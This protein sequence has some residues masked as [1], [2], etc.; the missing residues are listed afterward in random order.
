MAIKTYVYD[1]E[2]ISPC[3]LTSEINNELEILIGLHR[4]YERSGQAFIEMKDELP[5]EQEALLENIVL[6]HTPS[7]PLDIPIN[8]HLIEIPEYAIDK[9]DKTYIEKSIRKV[10]NDIKTDTI[11]WTNPYDIVLLGGDFHASESM[12]G[13][14]FRI[15]IHFAEND[16][17]G[18]VTQSANIGETKIHGQW[19]ENTV[20]KTYNIS[21]LLPDMTTVV[22]LGECILVNVDEIHCST[23]L[24]IDIPAGSYIQSVAVPIPY[25]HINTYPMNVVIGNSTHRGT[26]IPKNSNFV[27]KYTSNSVGEKNVSII[28][29]YYA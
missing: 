3:Q 28:V 13:D 4:C 29:E 15:E 11:S 10:I 9:V 18:Q 14:D 2:K 22:D 12:V 21:V 8:T 25:I 26:L 27:V 20:W 17:V 7:G 19:A 16:I 6:Q 24:P 1:K 5:T 23:P